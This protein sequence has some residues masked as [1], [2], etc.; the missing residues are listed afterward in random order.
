MIKSNVKEDSLIVNAILAH[1]SR[2]SG[3]LSIDY[4]MY[5]LVSI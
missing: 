2:Q 4:A 5:S 3:K 1:S